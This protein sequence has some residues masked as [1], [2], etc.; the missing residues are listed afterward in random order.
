MTVLHPLKSIP[1][2][3]FVAALMAPMSWA[4]YTLSS[5][6]VVT[7]T[8][9]SPY[10]VSD[11]NLIHIQNGGYLRVINGD[12]VNGGHVQLNSSA[13]AVIIDNGGVVDASWQ[14][15]NGAGGTININAP[16]VIN[17]GKIWANA[18]GTGNAG[19]VNIQAGT[20]TQGA[21]GETKAFGGSQS[22]G[23][24]G[25][26]SINATGTVTIA[27]NMR[28]SG[29][30]GTNP[31]FGSAA[32]AIDIVGNGVTIQ[33]GADLG[34]LGG[35]TFTV[36]S[37]NGITQNGT[38]SV[39]GSNTVKGGT[40]S[41]IAST[42]NVTVNGI[43]HATG[44]GASGG[45]AVIATATNG[46]VLGGVNA[47]ISANGGTNTGSAS[48]GNAGT[49]TLTG[50]NVTLTGNSGN[51][52]IKADGGESTVSGQV[53]NAGT[54]QLNAT[55]GNVTLDGYKITTTGRHGG[56]V[57]INATG[58]ITVK[59]N[60]YA[61]ANAS[62]RLV[63]N[64]GTITLDASDI[65]IT[66]HNAYETLIADGTQDPNVLTGQ[67]NGGTIALNATNAIGITS[68]AV[69][70]GI[71]TAVLTARGSNSQTPGD[72]GNVTLTGNSIAFNETVTTNNF[73]RGFINVNGGRGYTGSNGDG[74]SAT[75]TSA[76]TMT[77]NRGKIDASAGI[78]QSGVVTNLNGD[79]GD[80]NLTSAGALT[81]TNSTITANARGNGGG[82]GSM[83]FKSNSSNVT[84]T[85]TF[86]GMFS[87]NTAQVTVQASNGS[88][89]QS[90]GELYARGVGTGG[91]GGNVDVIFSNSGTANL[92][93]VDANSYYTA[94]TAS[95]A[96]TGA[97]G[98]VEITGGNL[99][100]NNTGSWIKTLGGNTSGNGGTIDIT[101]AGD[102]YTA[103]NT[104]ID[105][106]GKT[107]AT[108]NKVTINA[109]DITING[110]VVASG[111]ASNHDGGVITMNA[112]GDFA[113]A[114]T[115]MINAGGDRFDSN[116]T[117]G[118]GGTIN[119]TTTNGDFNL[120][121]DILANGSGGTNGGTINMN[122]DG[123]LDII[124]NGRIH[125][126]SLAGSSSGNGGTININADNITINA[127][128]SNVSSID[129]SSANGN[130]GSVSVVANGT[131]DIDSSQ[132]NIGRATIEASSFYR[133]TGGTVLIQTIGNGN[134]T[135]SFDLNGPNPLVAVNGGDSFTGGYDAGTITIDSVKHIDFDNDT[136]VGGT[137]NYLQANGG[138][139]LLLFSGG[140]GGRINI[141][142]KN[143]TN[144]ENSGSNNFQVN[145]GSRGWFGSNGSNGTV[146]Q[147]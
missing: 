101:L 62:N 113:V 43:T 94:E 110:N 138:D 96:T 125:A 2:A 25:R 91:S 30:L 115:G 123:D 82:G 77:I 72:G 136:G 59:G 81:L 63:G 128:N 135:I 9:A 3:L 44:Y 60:S 80:I 70:S 127:I 100:L 137:P 133:G 21:T 79:A 8:A 87:D 143:N 46:D 117:P 39:E 145:G 10:V 16:T 7:G 114:P 4:D 84:L 37:T 122:I 109:D 28:T 32:N 139:S 141:Y 47:N 89:T 36:N 38:V 64:G 35:G 48:V 144:I 17:N 26:I 107:T 41:L 105:S 27:G 13:G 131:I 50:R 11:S 104:Q 88:I 51:I 20:F 132:N 146:D 49:V 142:S 126:T 24:G 71:K 93:R 116:I 106:S 19:L 66:A 74:G 54:V 15:T 34:A 42:G 65:A 61:T 76:T 121:G 56:T 90:G 5:T 103:N 140:D 45:G 98:T 78:N 23:L 55:A 33:S 12:G 97:G 75:L 29:K 111:R 124:N 40:L 134:K 22:L 118:D 99:N 6:S 57:D 14:G 147:K 58:N 83:L 130:A 52:N 68:T 92:F 18:N 69:S 112:N 119:L 86:A 31:V 67:G 120:Q 85:N 129:V 73:K 53:G 102:L 1:A 108:L 95:D